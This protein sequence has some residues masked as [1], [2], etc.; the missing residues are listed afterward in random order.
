MERVEYFCYMDGV[1]MEFYAEEHEPGQ[2]DIG[3][4]KGLIFGRV[5][6]SKE[7]ATQALIVAAQAHVM[8]GLA[9]RDLICRAL[10]LRH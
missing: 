2:W 4:S 1:Q 7:N 3:P 9:V 8:G 6:G 10:G 5:M